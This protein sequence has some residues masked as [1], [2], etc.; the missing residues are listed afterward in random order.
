MK[1]NVFTAIY[2]I[3]CSC[4]LAWGQAGNVSPVCPTGEIHY[5]HFNQKLKYLENVSVNIHPSSGHTELLGVPSPP[6]VQTVAGNPDAFLDYLYDFEDGHYLMTHLNKIPYGSMPFNGGSERR[7]VYVTGK[8]STP[9]SIP[10]DPERSAGMGTGNPAPND[11]FTDGYVFVEA[12]RSIVPNQSMTFAISYQAYDKVKPDGFFFLYNHGVRSTTSLK[13]VDTYRGEAATSLQFNLQNTLA[14]QGI[15]NVPQGANG[16]RSAVE[17]TNI[18]P[19]LDQ[20]GSPEKEHTVFVTLNSEIS[21]AGLEEGQ[22]ARF[23]ILPYTEKSLEGAKRKIPLEFVV[24]PQPIARAHDPNFIIADRNSYIRGIGPGGDPVYPG[25][26]EVTYLAHFQNIGEA[27][28]T[29]VDLAI[30]VDTKLQTGTFEIVDWSPKV[31]LTDQ[32]TACASSTDPYLYYEVD[33]QKL[34]SLYFSFHHVAIQGTKD[35]KADPRL[36]ST[37]WVKYK[38]K[39]L[40]ISQHTA[41]FGSTTE[42]QADITFFDA[43]GILPSIQTNVSKIKLESREFE[44]YGAFPANQSVT[45][46]QYYPNCGNSPCEFEVTPC[47]CKGWQVVGHCLSSLK[48]IGFVSVPLLV[49]GLG[50]NRRRRRERL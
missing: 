34:G 29:R 33:C 26:V 10:D 32:D 14:D 50:L 20:V 2:L 25:C 17:F 3:F 37:G 31:M 45:M 18:E 1:K 23:A 49:I 48:V 42:A 40:P 30:P 13:C 19:S 11:R 7:R 8:Y 43:R 22:S 46:N 28:A 35:Q 5:N 16:Y 27:P 4:S 38:M 44:I 39:T 21:L 6:R 36:P 12:N 47:P 41:M 15:V 9:D 24:A